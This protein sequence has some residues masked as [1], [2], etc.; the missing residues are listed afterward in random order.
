MTARVR[1][2]FL[3]TPAFAVPALDALERA[4][5]EVR[6]VVAQPDRPAGR[7]R[8]LREPETKVWARGRGVEV[9]QPEKVRDGTLAAALAPM[10]PDVLCVAAYGRILGTD[11]LRIAPFG[12]VNVHAS[13]L[14]RYRGAAPIQWAI[15]RGETETG[16]SIMAMDEGLD[17]GDVLLQRAEAIRPDD[18]AESLSGRLSLLGG[19]ALATA[20]ALLERGEIVPVRQDGTKATLAPV[21]TRED[22]RIDWSLPAPEVLA[23]MR[24]FAP[25]PGSWTTLD[26][27]VVK[28]LAAEP[29]EP[30]AGRAPGSGLALAGRGIAVACAHPSALLVRRIQLE[31]RAAQGAVDFAN[32]LRRTELAFGT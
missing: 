18:T 19:E 4:G 5:H 20:L 2:V 13:L 11:L 22:G 25:W 10:R 23:R 3:G 26:G 6:A 30:L 14:P 1:V 29:G 9:L 16:V 31:G 8:A 21:L 17:T 28:V 24:A 7:G 12:A 27:K 15:A 32:G